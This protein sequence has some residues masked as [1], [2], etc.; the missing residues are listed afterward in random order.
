MPTIADIRAKYPNAA[1]LSD[2][3]LIGVV[4]NHYGTTPDILRDA[5]G[6]KPPQIEGGFFPAAKQAVGSFIKGAGQVASDVIPG[7]DQNNAVSRYGQGLIDAN[8]TA[9]R[10]LED[11]ASRPLTAV[12]EATGNAVPSMGGMVAARALGQGITAAA[13]LAGPFAPAVAL[14]GQ[15]VSW[16][17][18]A[19]IA[20]LP[21]YGG[22]RDKQI[23]HDPTNQDD[24]KAKAVA[25]L[26]AAAVGAI[27]QKFGPQQWAMGMLTKEGRTA[28]AEKFAET[29]LAKSIGFGLAK[30]AAIEGAEELA[31]N[32][33]EQLAS[34]EN[35]TTPE[36]IKETVFG[37]AMGAIGGGVL[38]G[39]AGAIAPRKQ[40]TADAIAAIGD[41][42]TA[43]EAIRA[44]ALAVAA[45]AGQ[46]W[47]DL[48]IRTPAEDMAAQRAAHVAGQQF[49]DLG[50]TTPQEDL[51]AQRAEALVNAEQAGA[52]ASR[53]TDAR[54]A[55]LG[56]QFQNLGITNHADDLQAQRSGMRPEAA[57]EQP[58]DLPPVDSGAPGSRGTE[59]DGGLDSQLGVPSNAARA[60]EPASPA[61]EPS[62]SAAPLAAAKP[63]E[64]TPQAPE[65]SP[66]LPQGE[67]T[68]TYVGK[69][70]KGMGRDAAKL[71]ASRR[72][73]LNDGNTYTAEEHGQ[74]MDNPWAVVGRKTL[75]TATAGKPVET[76]QPTGEITLSVGKTG[77]A[78]AG[79]KNSRS[80]LFDRN[81]FLAFLGKHGL[82][83]EKDKKGSLKVEF[84]PDFNPLV[85]GHGPMFHRRGK[86]LDVLH[87]AAIE[88]GFLTPY[89]TV[90]DLSDLIRKV[91]RKERVEPAFSE[92]GMA[93]LEQRQRE[94]EESARLEYEAELEQN[95]QELEAE[96]SAEREA[97]QAME[98]HSDAEIEALDIATRE[99][100]TEDAMRALGFDEQ[101]IQ[102]A[103]AAEQRSQGQT[104]KNREQA[105]EAQ[106]G[107]TPRTDPQGDGQARAETEDLTAPTRQDV[108]AQQDRVDNAQA[109][110]EKAQIDR[111]ADGFQLQTQSQESRQDNT[112]DMFGGPSVDDFQKAQERK[113]GKAASGPDLFSGATEQRLT[114]E[115]AGKLKSGDVVK[116]DKGN[117][118]LAHA[119]RHKWLDAF[120]IVN[121]KA[122]VNAE[123]KVTFHLDP[124]T[125]QAYPERNHSPVYLTGENLY[126]GKRG[127]ATES[128]TKNTATPGQSATNETAGQS[129]AAVLARRLRDIANNVE[130]HGT[131]NGRRQLDAR[132]AE[133]AIRRHMESSG[134]QAMLGG[135]HT[136]PVATAK[137]A[138]GK[139][140]LTVEG[141]RAIAEKLE[142]SETDQTPKP[143]PLA[144]KNSGSRVTPQVASQQQLESFIGI[145]A[146]SIQQLREVDVERVLAEA[147]VPFR[148]SLAAHIKNNRPEFADEIREV[149]DSLRDPTPAAAQTPEAIRAEADLKNALADLGDILGK[150]TRLNMMP[151]QE[152]KLLPVLVRL[153]D[154]AFRLGY[155]KFKDA[156]KFA[157]DQIRAALG[158]EAADSLTLDHMQGAYIA[159]GAREG[160]DSKRAVI[161]VES[162]A[163]IENHTAKAQNGAQDVPSTNSR[164]ERDRPEPTPGATVGTP[165]PP[166]SRAADQGTRT[167]GGRAGSAGS[168]SQGDTGVS[169]DGT[170]AGGERGDQLLRGDD[171]QPGLAGSDARTD[172]GERSGDSGITGVPPE[173]IPANKV[174][175]VAGSGDAEIRSRQQQ[176]SAST[177]VE[178]GL[179][180]VRATLPYLLEGQQEDV[181]KAEQ[182][183][184]KPDGYGMLFTNGTGTGK[185]FVGLGAAKRFDLQGKSNILIVVPDEKIASDWISSGTALGLKI[186]KLADTKGAG[187]GVVVTSYANLGENDALAKRNWDLVV[188]DEA[189]TLMQSAQS[190]VTGYLKALRAITH[191][192]E[193][194]EQRFTMLHRADI[195]RATEIEKQIAANVK[196]INS[197]DT[198]DQV[199]RS[200]RA[201]NEQLER[202]LRP[203]NDKLWRARE[204]VTADIDSR[205]G[206]KRTRAM[207]LSATPFAYE[208]NTDWAS[209]FLFDYK[210]GYPYDPKASRPYN[211]PDPRQHFMMTHFGYTMRYDKLTEPDGSKVNRGLMQRQ[212]NGWL[213]SKGALSGRMLD[214]PADYDRRFVLVDSAIGNRI[215][216]A[217]AW[218]NDK[219]REQRVTNADKKLSEQDNG[220]STLAK[221]INDQFDYLTR[222]YFLEGIKAREVIPMVQKH[223]SM[224]RKVV[225]FHDYKKGGAQNPFKVSARLV[226]DGDMADAIEGRNRAVEAFAKDFP[227]L[228][229]GALDS[230]E[231]PIE[232]FK[233]NI[234][235]VLLVNGDE[236]K[237]DLL[238][239][240]KAFQSDDTG[241]TVM[242][243]QSAK[244]KGWSG[245]DTTGKHQRVLINL[246]Q[247]T[248]PTL[249]IQQ[250][251]RIYRTGQVSN[252]IMRYL[253][254]GTNWE[255]WA[256]ATTIA[257]RASTA[258]NL[259]MGEQSRALRDAFI[260]AFEESDAY[261]PGHEGEG[262]G[263]K[264]RDKAANN[265]ITE[266]DRAKTFYW[267]TQKK[268]SATKAQEGVD[269]F[270][271]PEPIGF[272]M[273]QW[274]DARGEEST[275][276]PSAGHG[277]IARWLPDNT[278]RT[279]IEPSTAL[280]S[281]LAMVMNPAED[282]IIEGQ[283][284][285]LDV[286]N[287]YDGIV[288]NPPFGSGGKTAIE[289]LAKAA[290][291]LRDGGRIVALIPTGPAADKRFE[292]W[293]YEDAERPAKPL[294]VDPK[295]GPIYKG[296]TLTMS[297]YGNTKTIV[298]DKVDGRSGGPWYVRDANTK[299]DGAINA[300]AINKVAP[301]GKRTETYNPAADL[302][303][304][305]DIK[306]PQVT[307]E[308]AG[309]AVAT[310]IVVIEKHAKESDMARRTALRMDF[311]GIDDINELFDQL[312]NLNFEKRSKPEQVEKPASPLASRD[313]K[314]PDA[315]PEKKAALP[316][317]KV[318]LGGKEYTVATYTTQAGKTKRGVWMDSKED[319]TKFSPRAFTTATNRGKWFV[320]E[321]WFNKGPSD[322]APAFSRAPFQSA[323]EK[324]VGNIK[325]N[326]QSG[327]GWIANIR[328][329]VSS[330]KVKA[331]EVEWSG[332]TDWLGLQQGKVTRDAVVQY[333]EGN[334]V[335][336]EE[337]TLGLNEAEISDAGNKPY[338]WA[339][340]E[341]DSGKSTRFTDAILSGE[342]L[343]SLRRIA[344][345]NPYV[346]TEAMEYLDGFQSIDTPT[347]YSQYTLP[348]GE[349]YREVLLTLPPEKKTIPSYEEWVNL[350]NMQDPFADTL[351]ILGI[352][353]EARKVD[354]S[355]ERYER[356]K[357]EMSNPGQHLREYKSNHWDQPNVLAHIRLNDR[358]DADGKR[359]LFV[360]EIQSDFGQSFKKQRDA[361]AKAVDND[362][363]GIIKRMKDAGVLEVNCD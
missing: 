96:T 71:E 22:I 286:V 269:Y 220:F 133:G 200:V 65:P 230:I 180:S 187:A 190:D 49:K 6:Y 128:P 357:R 27:E 328:G 140:R 139:D 120:P 9:I 114:P 259:G 254:T 167:D 68:S 313:S 185:T 194:A 32:P 355:R 142:R 271:T 20:G 188:A 157:L 352:D 82:W 25:G 216:E 147:P 47:Q 57:S 61:G 241:P 255:R 361:I 339:K 176:K 119:A 274:L 275:L 77:E 111:E 227:D 282:R 223:L 359:V 158:D 362:F 296:D 283:F 323:L 131:D 146:D 137:I 46:Q 8:P 14:A 317:Q 288:M 100:S 304:L 340:A 5:I 124:E 346:P 211:Q 172:F 110:D 109:L 348:G 173:P 26:G 53:A 62:G 239:R 289:H 197:D 36:S 164:L 19:A 83:H 303:L 113:P 209:G 292:K 310:R 44:A 166:G 351:A 92:T 21:S 320:D 338:E 108:E 76:T 4:A 260:A 226:P 205:Q 163:D 249:A 213:K 165:V 72:N 162:K 122:D 175:A 279:V 58:S 7:V 272:K 224:G 228:V 149:M 115:T 67:V 281:R 218:L 101:E 258:E 112:G 358:T 300:V 248:A 252:A 31:Q 126:D 287:K 182:R 123:N 319:A 204:A 39:A 243:V 331:D 203:L 116:D 52:S 316:G 308:R 199:L 356:E 102:D 45:N 144:P 59:P 334:G 63:A 231:A 242:L 210:E 342:S 85:R 251:G 235:G 73:R 212:F 299:P 206:E 293:F 34:F 219:S 305:A 237:G 207:F 145:A 335:R 159:L 117:K 129:L 171:R 236:A 11:I 1:S 178:P 225:V 315:K 90:E 333:L 55:A 298:I 174:G 265:A 135:K 221:E 192:P 245:H 257:S 91:L 191:H 309:T 318:T 233:K 270:A 98:Q 40:K 311:T 324:E 78:P 160:T 234:P 56:Q 86:Q 177:R 360:E 276:E 143:K 132:W 253:N 48:G 103:V 37:G 35:P 150:N 341:E 285:D 232:V 244:N 264:E 30:G 277:A 3:D 155:H 294:F 189:H 136:G 349:N 60:L 261:P 222:R 336:V 54:I 321:Y 121:G 312:E 273:A 337:V 95:R 290:T 195:D 196:I 17:G 15:A 125:A 75:P 88:E 250:E 81:P 238:K 301:T 263:G 217:L 262:T 152:Q 278:S 247:P 350:E 344:N 154:A 326:A 329:L 170:A 94:A 181:H 84:S 80:E 2:D 343:D 168:G 13:P 330:G 43:D 246:G 266:Y 41:S 215:D 151:E 12:T 291:H 256:F 229:G 69:Y 179:E 345:G 141:L 42:K 18:P 208:K 325:A 161:D 353:A 105:D 306:L 332:I 87:T 327:M 38:G 24:W 268:T 97:I 33:I 297:G 322:D 201:E 10:S 23:L 28:L 214:V 169:L 130:S 363:E 148:A 267:A 183:F 184:A 280:R 198:M 186:T 295:H 302:N 193:G 99:T 284:E 138:I 354:T 29:S 51:D 153:F 89:S 240:Y 16:L 156:A 127:D 50:L 74:D 93:R 79:G 104:G 307:F 202:T 118:Y 66:Q 347:K 106:A 134:T 314:L 70:G 107:E 64:L